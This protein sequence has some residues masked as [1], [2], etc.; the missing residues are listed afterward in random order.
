MV[1]YSVFVLSLLD[2][3]FNV[4]V[5]TFW[6][7]LPLLHDLYIVHHCCNVFCEMRMLHDDA[8]DLLKAIRWVVQ[9][10]VVRCM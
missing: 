5:L 6:L 4:H 3:E 1:L 8:T 10:S 7:P 9:I 2:C